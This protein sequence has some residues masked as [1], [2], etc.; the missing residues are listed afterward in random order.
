MRSDTYEFI[1]DTTSQQ[2]A[3]FHVICWN[4]DPNDGERLY[5]DQE[6]VDKVQLFN[7]IV[8]DHE[9]ARHGE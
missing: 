4:C 7:L 5:P 8:E 3:T 6:F 1:T 9:P 2:Y